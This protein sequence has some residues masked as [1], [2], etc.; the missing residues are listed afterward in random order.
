MSDLGSEELE[1]EGE[2]DIGVSSGRKGFHVRGGG[3]SGVGRR[4]PGGRQQRRAAAPAGGTTSRA[5]RAALRPGRREVKRRDVW[6]PPPLALPTPIPPPIKGE[7]F[8]AR[9]FGI[10][11]SLC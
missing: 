11:F 6:F 4:S 8:Q 3:A 5:S 7:D 9:G 2:N 10:S 1:E